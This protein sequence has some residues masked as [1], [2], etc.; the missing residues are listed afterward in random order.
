VSRASVRPRF[1]AGVSSPRRV[2]CS[3]L[4]H[5]VRGAPGR[6]AACACPLGALPRGCRDTGVR[7]AP[8][9]VAPRS[10]STLGRRGGPVAC[11]ARPLLGMATTAVVDASRG[12][13]GRF[14]QS[15]ETFPC[16]D[17]EN[18]PRRAVL[19]ARRPA[20]DRRRNPGHRARARRVARRRPGRHIAAVPPQTQVC[21]AVRLQTRR[22][23][24]GGG[25]PEPLGRPRRV[26]DARIARTS[27]TTP[28]LDASA[29]PH[30]V[31][32]QVCRR[33]AANLTRHGNRVGRVARATGGAPNHIS[34]VR[35]IR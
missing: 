17:T 33:T 32:R 34:P 18:P 31:T 19:I 3:G 13:E 24:R 35:H 4:G 30:I 15:T 26:T 27:A 25:L 20:G 29:D 8:Q 11:A 2:E 28:E 9:A 7:G 21:S 1:L 14:A 23:T 10:R 5:V 12:R 16:W 22:V 6:E